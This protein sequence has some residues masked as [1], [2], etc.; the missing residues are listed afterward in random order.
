MNLGPAGVIIK[1]PVQVHQ[2]TGVCDGSRGEHS[3]PSN[4]PVQYTLLLSSS[5]ESGLKF[6]MAKKSL[7]AV[8]LR[9]PWWVSLLIA[10]V[11]GLLG[12]ALLPDTLRVGGALSGLPFLVIACIAAWRQWPLPSAAR[13]DETRLALATMAWPAFARLLEQAFQRDGYRVERSQTE[14]VD[15][16]LERQGRSMLVCAR[17]WKS[18]RTGLE[19]LRAL[20]AARKA[21]EAADAL[22]IGLGPLSD[23]ATPFAAECRIAVWQAPELAHALRGLPLGTSKAR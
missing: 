8:L 12:F 1:S 13:V 20:Q 11:V 23:N 22:Y 3:A 17:R 16:V 4:A 5:P 14:G 19:A 2:L 6:Q 9:S 10:L 18:A 15:F 7:F 21:A